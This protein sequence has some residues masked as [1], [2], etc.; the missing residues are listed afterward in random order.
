MVCSAGSPVRKAS[1]PAAAASPSED[2]AAPEITPTLCTTSGPYSHTNGSAPKARAQRSR[3]S[4][5]AT[6]PASGPT[7]PRA[8]PL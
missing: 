5:N 6:P 3:S 2:A 1:S 8:V 7:N 4:V